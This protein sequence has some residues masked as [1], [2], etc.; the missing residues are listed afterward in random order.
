[1]TFSTRTYCTMG[2]VQFLLEAYVGR[3]E[4]EL[5][6]VEAESTKVSNGIEDLI[7]THGEGEDSVFSVPCQCALIFNV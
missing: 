3:F 7:R 6:S 4:Q 2:S 5:N 1:M